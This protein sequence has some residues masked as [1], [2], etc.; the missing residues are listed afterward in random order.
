M[1]TRQAVWVAW[2]V[3]SI[4]IHLNY[5]SGEII[6]GSPN[7]NANY[8]LHNTDVHS[9]STVY[10][11][12][13]QHVW[14]LFESKRETD[15]IWSSVIQCIIHR[16]NGRYTCKWLSYKPYTCILRHGTQDQ[17]TVIKRKYKQKRNTRNTMAWIILSL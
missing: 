12:I 2:Y 16:H 6:D 7:K 15:F 10:S 4:V 5:I 13:G 9:P 11:Y 17:V 1:T 3:I 8:V 14:F